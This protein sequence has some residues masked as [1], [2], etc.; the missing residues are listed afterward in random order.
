MSCSQP[1]FCQ[2][3]WG[4]YKRSGVGRDLG[5]RGLEPYQETKQLTTYVGTG[6]LGW[7]TLPTRSK[8]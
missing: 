3:P 4:G 2:A 8:L 6:P 7:Y 1:A 5:E